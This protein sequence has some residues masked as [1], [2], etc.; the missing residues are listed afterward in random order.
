MYSTYESSCILYVVGHRL[1]NGTACAAAEY[2][3]YRLCCRVDSFTQ[4]SLRAVMAPVLTG[5]VNRDE[6][7][8]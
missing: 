6:V 2:L 5:E 3:Q 7:L 8:I 1:Q 4:V